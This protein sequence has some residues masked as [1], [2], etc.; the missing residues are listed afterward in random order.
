MA[1]YVWQHDLEGERH[2]LRLM[3]DLLDP[4][5]RFHLSRIGIASGWRCLEIG[6]GNGSLSQWLAERVG[7]TGQ[8]IATD[9]RTDLMQGIASANLEVRRL[10]VVH[11][12][13]PDAPYDL[14]AIRALLHHIP[15]RRQV[16]HRMG[17]WLRPG[18]WLFVQEPDFYPTWT[19]EPPSQ[20]QFWEQFIRWAKTHRIDYYVGRKIAP[21]L[22]SEG[23]INIFSEGHAIVYNGRS[24]FAD[25]WDYGIREVAG[26][27]QNEGFVSPETLNEFFALYRDPAYWTTSISFIATTAQ[28]P[29][30]AASR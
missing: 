15:E 10:D 2:R 11:D 4:S 23:L 5:S 19:V 9:I 21:W 14:I 7:P 25:W 13:P 6:A 18:G 24:K 12:E 16:V 27:L 28:R 22:Q 17:Q 29:G 30:D 8:V 20:K 1:E 3:S 26:K